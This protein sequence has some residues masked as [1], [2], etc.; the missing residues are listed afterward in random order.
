[1]F[2]VVYLC[3]LKATGWKAR[4]SE[5]YVLCRVWPSSWD[6]NRECCNHVLGVGN[7]MFAP[8]IK[9]STFRTVIVKV[10]NLKTLRSWTESFLFSR[11]SSHKGAI[12]LGGEWVVLADFSPHAPSLPY[13]SLHLNLIDIY[14]IRQTNYTSW[15]CISCVDHIM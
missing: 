5:R 7:L 14:K 2:M 8:W 12:H 3:L 1:M 9:T 4:A 11:P 15:C 10:E 6:L 13:S